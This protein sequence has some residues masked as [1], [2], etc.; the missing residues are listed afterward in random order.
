[1]V[2]MFGPV[3]ASVVS[4]MMWLIIDANGQNPSGWA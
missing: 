4:L 1:M 2:W 3:L